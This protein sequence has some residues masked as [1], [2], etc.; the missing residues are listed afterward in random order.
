M[1][2]GANTD[3]DF[4]GSR[5]KASRVRRRNGRVTHEKRKAELSGYEGTG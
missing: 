2:G 4:T 1:L 3:N 5:A